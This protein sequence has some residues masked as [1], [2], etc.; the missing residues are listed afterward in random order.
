MKIL[1]CHNY[2]QQ[3]GG[4]DQVFSDECWLLQSHGHQVV[5]FTQ[6]N[7]SLTGIGRWAMLR[8]TVWNKEVEG[9]L[10]E[11]I[12]RERPQIMH[13]HNTFPLLSPAVYYAARRE[14]VAVVQTLHNFRLLCPAATLLRDGQVCEKCVGKRFA[15]PAI[16]HACYRNSR[17]ATAAVTAM[18]SSHHARKTWT[19]A[20]D[21][22]IAL[23]D[24]SRQKFIEGGLPAGRI[25][26][27]PNF[28]QPDPGMGRGNGNYAVFAGRLAPEKGIETLLDAWSQ[29]PQQ[30]ALR[31]VGDGPL[32]PLVEQAA[33]NDTRI[34][35]LGQRPLNEAVSIVG[36]AAMLVMPSV[37]YETFG[38]TI[39]EAFA[40]GTPV[41]ASR[42]GAMQEL[43]DE[44]RTGLLF[45]P[46][47]PADLA[48]KVRWLW[49]RPDRRKQMCQAARDEY[50]QRYTAQSNYLRLM[51]IY[52]EATAGRDREVCFQEQ[53]ALEPAQG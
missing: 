11:V 9:E 51:E 47:D 41:I 5:R 3:P 42:M 19:G 45:K 12:R 46:A 13:C 15:W 33:R 34:E 30:I 1:V 36:D 20:V 26:V 4:E 38:R 37:W 50:E 49:D 14:N 29:M 21:R 16:Q 7:D 25:S 6:H 24:F 18:L 39:V 23:T 31:I 2:Y 28:V 48:A 53:A 52:R 22:Y 44:P 27:K 40:T 35:W 8:K 10:L 43:V 32:A 17:P